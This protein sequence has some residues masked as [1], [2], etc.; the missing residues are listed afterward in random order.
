MD[1][2]Y[3]EQPCR[4]F[5]IFKAILF[6]DPKD[7]KE[8]VVLSSFVAGG[9]G[10]VIFV[11]PETGEGESHVIPGDAGA[12][13]LLNYKNEKLL[14]GTC[15]TYG[16]LHCMDLADR[17][18]KEPL[19]I[20]GISYIWDLNTASDGMVYGGTYPG[21]V[22]LKYDPEAH[23]L[24]NLGPMTPDEGN[25]YSRLVFTPVEGKVYV[26]CGMSSSCIGI[27]D[28]STG[29]MTN[30]LPGCSIQ[31][32]SKD[33]LYIKSPEKEMFVDPVDFSELPY[34]KFSDELNIGIDNLPVPAGHLLKLQSGKTFGISGQRYFIVSED[35]KDITF[36][37]IP[38]AP[39]PTE[40]FAMTSG[41]NGIL[42]GATGLGQTMFSYDPKDGSYWNS[43]IVTEKGGEVYGIV[44]YNGKIYMTSYAGGDHMVYDPSK[45]WNQRENINPVTLESIGP[46]YIRPQARSF[47]GPDNCIWTGWIAQYGSYGLAITRIDPKTNEVTM[48]KDLIPSQGIGSITAGNDCIYF[49]TNGSGNGL[50]TKVEEFY[51]VKMNLEGKILNKV[52]FDAGV[53]LSC[54]YYKN[55]EVVLYT[56]KGSDRSMYIYDK[57]S[58]EL[59]ERSEIDHIGERIVDGKPGEVIIGARMYDKDTVYFGLIIAEKST[60]KEI[61]R[62]ALPAH[63]FSYTYNEKDGNIYFGCHS[64]LY[65]TEY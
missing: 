10:E 23:V 32:A 14:V 20:E 7:G 3:L 36:H 64:K 59:K 4:N 47:L 55:D 12:W 31:K 35:A 9:T 58:L 25:L 38:A 29:K 50:K 46:G 30:V 18:W 16:F 57:D 39:P 19:S 61:K 37:K 48:F 26:N 43:D 8:K 65:K 44:E 27:Y 5:C 63:S 22:L 2:Q 56:N 1:Y 11:D 49:T 45:P 33:Y 17:K 54:V 13:A 21:C 24:E 28:I 52:K 60:F 15:G 34:D 53:N 51:L 42:Y 41:K 6:I 40:I 62:I